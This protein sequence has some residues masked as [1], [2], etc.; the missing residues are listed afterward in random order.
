MLDL[1]IHYCRIADHYR[2]LALGYANAILTTVG[3]S[4][5]DKGPLT[6][7]I[8][9]LEQPDPIWELLSQLEKKYVRVRTE[10]EREDGKIRR[11]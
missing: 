11:D 8:R 7:Q 6:E 5:S 2:C 4:F 10:P 9:F 3:T 1:L